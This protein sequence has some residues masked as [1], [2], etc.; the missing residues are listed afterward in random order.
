MCGRF[1]RSSPVEVIRREFR[2][3][4]GEVGEL[5]PRYNVCP[6]EDVAAVVSAEGGRR[7]G[8]L[9]WGFPLGSPEQPKK[10]LINARSE[11][12]DRLPAFR[13]ALLRR[14]CLVVADGFYEWRRQPSGPRTPHFFRLASRRPVAFAAIWRHWKDPDGTTRAGCALLTCPANRLVAPVHDRMPV[15]LAASAV[16]SWLDRD[17]TEPGILKSLLVPFA[18]EAMEG[19]AVSPRVNSPRNDS[20]ELILPWEEP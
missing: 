11:T 14:R 16:D 12:V 4:G 9:R 15:M 6:G 13:E 5:P 18:A 7:L 10:F 17:L 3:F 19:F 20:P 1:V 8:L 2:A